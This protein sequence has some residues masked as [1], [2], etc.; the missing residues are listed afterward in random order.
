MFTAIDC[1]NPKDV[2]PPGST[3]PSLQT[4]KHLEDA[5]FVFGCETGY[6]HIGSSS[7]VT[8]GENGRWLLNT[9]TCI[10]I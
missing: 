4:T 10:G 5:S 3:V 6:D 1:G 2:L 8:C 7:T 9:S